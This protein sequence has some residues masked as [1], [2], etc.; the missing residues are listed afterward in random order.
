MKNSEGAGRK[1]WRSRDTKMWRREK[2]PDKMDIATDAFIAAIL[3]SEEYQAYRVE[4][5][6]VKQ[7]PDLKAQIDEFRK[8]NFELQLS[9]DVDFDKLNRFEREYE[10]FRDNQLVSDFLAAEL[11]FCRMMQK[12]DM[13]VTSRLKFE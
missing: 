12:I 13:Q 2:G 4:L 6:K 7:V 10:N 3:E 9:Q 11:A 8:R 5:E 1:G